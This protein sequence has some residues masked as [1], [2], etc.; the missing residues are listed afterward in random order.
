MTSRPL[1]HRLAAVACTAI[2]LSSCTAEAPEPTSAPTK[3]TPSSPL[4]TSS[5]TP[6]ADPAVQEAE[7]AVLEAYRTYWSVS[8]AALAD[9][10]ADL[11]ED[12]DRFIVDEAR[13][14]TSTRSN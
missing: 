9:P 2:L 5:P 1:L 11:P 12:F 8:V 13:A 10:S 3:S 4:V 7:A 14:P 6:T